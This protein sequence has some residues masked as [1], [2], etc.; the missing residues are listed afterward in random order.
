MKGIP[1]VLAL[2]TILISHVEGSCVVVVLGWVTDGWLDVV[3]GDAPPPRQPLAM[4]VPTMRRASAAA[5]EF[6]IRI[7]SIPAKKEKRV[8]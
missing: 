8:V 7:P 6:F 2:Q 3:D 5:P 1:V 4:R